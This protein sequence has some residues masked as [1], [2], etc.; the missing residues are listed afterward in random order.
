[1]VCLPFCA[2]QHQAVRP[3]VIP[4]SP[5]FVIPPVLLF[6]P[7]WL[8]TAQRTESGLPCYPGERSNKNISRQGPLTSRALF[9]HLCKGEKANSLECP[10]DIHEEAQ[11]KVAALEAGAGGQ[12]SC[13]LAPA[14]GAEQRV[15][16]NLRP[17]TDIWFLQGGSRGLLSRFCLAAWGFSQKAASLWSLPPWEARCHQGWLRLSARDSQQASVWP[18]SRALLGGLGRRLTG[19]GRS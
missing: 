7:Q 14:Q 8:P 17:E 11:A 19:C 5:S 16:R 18:S 12:S 3:R 4:S 9:S 10:R 1:M 15:G 6:S 13:A 2:L